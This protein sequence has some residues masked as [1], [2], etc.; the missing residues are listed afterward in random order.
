MLTRRNPPEI[1]SPPLSAGLAAWQW[2]AREAGADWIAVQER[3]EP[4]GGD[5]YRLRTP[6]DARVDGARAP[7]PEDEL[8]PEEKARMSMGLKPKRQQL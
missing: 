3:L 7:G 6:G 4:C 2:W 8:T 1:E 5:Q